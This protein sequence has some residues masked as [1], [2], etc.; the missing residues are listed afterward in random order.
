[1]I[2]RRSAGVCDACVSD[3]QCGAG[4]LCVMQYFDEVG[5]SE[6]EVEVGYFCFWRE[7]ATEA[8]APAGDCVNARPYVDTRADSESIEGT[9]ATVCGLRVTTCA[10][11]KDYSAKTC[12]GIEDDAVCGDARF[13]SDAYC[14]MFSASTYR[15]TT[16]CLSDDDCD[17][18]A[19]CTAT[20]PK[21]CALQ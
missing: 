18:G 8:G 13:A 10:G 6:G 7:D 1:M 20:A 21:Y 12:A 15:C 11:Y 16:P 2:E 19:T 5:D 9:D 17:V 4:Q 14:E 3:A